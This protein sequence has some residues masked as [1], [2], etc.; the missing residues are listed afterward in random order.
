MEQ[1]SFSEIP[2][3]RELPPNLKIDAEAMGKFK[4][5]FWPYFESGPVWNWYS[6][7]VNDAIDKAN[8]DFLLKY[9]FHLIRLLHSEPSERTQEGDARNRRKGGGR[10]GRGHEIPA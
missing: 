1:T 2:Y 9:T 8:R 6:D 7:A 5:I 3:L 10:T 4:D